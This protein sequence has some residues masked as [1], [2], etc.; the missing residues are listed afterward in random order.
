[1]GLNH[2]ETGGLYY[3]RENSTQDN[4]INNINW[5]TTNHTR[6]RVDVAISGDISEFLKAN[7]NNINQL[8]GLPYWDNTDI[9]SCCSMYLK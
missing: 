9:F 5:L 6:T 1:M 2:V 7:E 4:I 3:D 8:E